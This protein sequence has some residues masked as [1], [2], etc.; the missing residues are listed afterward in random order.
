M[1]SDDIAQGK[2]IAKVGIAAVR[3]PKPIILQFTQ[4]VGLERLIE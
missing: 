3:P 1:N 2:M 4:N